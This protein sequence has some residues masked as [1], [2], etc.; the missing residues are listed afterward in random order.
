[1]RRRAMCSDRLTVE[2]LCFAL[3]VAVEATGGFG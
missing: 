3:W 1:M 2:W